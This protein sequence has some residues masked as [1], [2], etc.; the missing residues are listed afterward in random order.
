M[1]DEINSNNNTDEEQE[2]EDIITLIDD[3]GRMSEFEVLDAIETDEGRFVAL[4]PL[5]SLDEESG[6]GEYIILQVVNVNG[7]EELAEIEDEELLEALA[8]VFLERFDEL[9]ETEEL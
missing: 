1:S 2:D 7:E 3:E 9:Y 4:L 5:A 6:E 8:D